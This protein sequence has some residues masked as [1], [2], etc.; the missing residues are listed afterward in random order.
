[1]TRSKVKR[2]RKETIDM[3]IYVGTLDRFGYVLRVIATSKAEAKRLLVAEY[4]NAYEEINHCRPSKETFRIAK[5]EIFVDEVEIG[6]VE[7]V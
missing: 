7:W 4:K 1:M 2:I 3:K 5:D 6:K